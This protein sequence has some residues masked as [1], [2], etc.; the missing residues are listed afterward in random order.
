MKLLN[1]EIKEI[2]IKEINKFKD[3][4]RLYN[5]IMIIDA[6]LIYEASM[7]YLMEKIILVQL[8]EKEQ[9]KRLA[10]RNIFTREESLKRINSQIPN[11]EK[12]EKADYIINN[13]NSVEKTKEQVIKRGEELTKIL[14]DS[15]DKYVKQFNVTEHVLEIEFEKALEIALWAPKKGGKAGG[16]KKRYA[17]KLLWEDG[18]KR[19]S[20]EVKIVGFEVVRSS[21]SKLDSNTTKTRTKHRY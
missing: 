19:V 17:Y 18:K 14:N 20:K 21:T 12:T 4:N 1:P 9:I 3:D 2:I 10:I 15:Y 5:K 7:D 8:N 16:A 13:N 11:K 6:P